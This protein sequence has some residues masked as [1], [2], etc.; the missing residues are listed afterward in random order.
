MDIT[1]CLTMSIAHI[2]RTTE[3][4]LEHEPDTNLMNL[5]VYKKSEYGYWIHVPE[6]FLKSDRMEIPFD[7]WRCMMM[8]YEN[9]CRWLCLDRDGM[10]IELLQT[11]DW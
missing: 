1:K 5:S 11:Y 6:D 10:E 9:D 2:T 3:E 4:K 8:A 7:L